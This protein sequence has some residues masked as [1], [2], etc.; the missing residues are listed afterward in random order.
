MRVCGWSST[1]V[2]DEE[3]ARWSSIAKF[4]RGSRRSDPSFRKSEDIDVV[5]LSKIRD[6]GIF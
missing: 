5:R 1:G 6:S 4:G 3:K 2:A